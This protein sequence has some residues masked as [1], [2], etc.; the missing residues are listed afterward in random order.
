MDEQTNDI[1]AKEY[2]SQRLPNKD[3]SHS[4]LREWLILIAPKYKIDP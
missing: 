3:Q 2:N 4:L 1:Y